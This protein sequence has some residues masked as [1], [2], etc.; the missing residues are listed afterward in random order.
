[1]AR[2]FVR[3]EVVDENLIALLRDIFGTASNAYSN[4]SDYL[5]TARVSWWMF[6][7]GFAGKGVEKRVVKAIHSALREWG[8]GVNKTI[9]LAERPF[10]GT[11]LVCYGLRDS[12][13]EDADL[14]RKP[15]SARRLYASE[16]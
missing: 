6:Q 4:L 9:A 8:I 12:E 11:R 2:P 15:I 3:T 5:S 1:M 13:Q 7:R 10:L 14:G 16:N